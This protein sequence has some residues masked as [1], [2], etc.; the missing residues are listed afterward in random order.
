MGRLSGADFKKYVITTWEIL[1]V[2]QFSIQTLD[3]P[4]SIRA[5][6]DGIFAGSGYSAATSS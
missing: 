2:V 4:S 5:E 3:T 1:R 6:S